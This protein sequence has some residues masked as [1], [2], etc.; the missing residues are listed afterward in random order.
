M[1]CVPP[2][3]G[4]YLVTEMQIIALA[5]KIQQAI[6]CE[7]SCKQPS[8]PTICVC[9]LLRSFHKQADA[10]RKCGATSAYRKHGA[11]LQS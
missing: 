6:K 9:S 3:V 11:D 8:G 4:M 1:A 7:P 5:R 10:G 2:V